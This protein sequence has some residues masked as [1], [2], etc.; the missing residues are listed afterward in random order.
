MKIDSKP[1][2]APIPRSATRA[3]AK[4][5]NGEAGGTEARAD[6]VEI[7]AFSARLS[8][9]EASLSKQPLIDEGK[10]NEIRRAMAEGRFTV[11]ADAIADS[12]MANV[13]E[14]LQ[15]KP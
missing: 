12:L 6:S 10:V 9:L 2:N 14:L 3:G 5:A 8:T 1:L 15:S 13:K 4:A 11:N 7:K